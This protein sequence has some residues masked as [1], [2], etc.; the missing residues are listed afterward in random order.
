MN[1]TDKQLI[2]DYPLVVGFP[3]LEGKYLLLNWHCHDIQNSIAVAKDAKGLVACFETAI[4]REW[5][6]QPV[7]V[8]EIE[9]VAPPLA[10]QLKAA[11][12]NRKHEIASF[13]GWLVRSALTLE[14]ADGKLP[15]G[16]RHCAL[17]K[18]KPEEEGGDE[19]CREHH[20]GCRN[21]TDGVVFKLKDFYPKLR[22]KYRNDTPAYHAGYMSGA[23]IASQAPLAD[24]ARKLFEAFDQHGHHSEGSNLRE[25]KKTDTGYFHEPKFF[26]HAVKMEMP[27]GLV[28]VREA[29][30]RKIAQ[31]EEERSAQY[32]A[33]QVKDQNEAAT[34]ARKL[35]G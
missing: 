20:I 29:M 35:F 13:G 12:L 5:D 14:E 17:Y 16:M 2:A 4:D 3:R 31:R 25:V 34:R 28:L 21:C 24:P 27:A 30:D 19:F 15:T 23:K 10:L 33:D 8:W 9:I 18:P 6:A 11:N 26:C 1:P 32:K 7:A 22:Q